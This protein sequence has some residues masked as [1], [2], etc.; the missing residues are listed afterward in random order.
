MTSFDMAALNAITRMALQL[1]Q[2]EERIEKSEK[3]ADYRAH[4][5]LARVDKLAKDMASSQLSQHH[6]TIDEIK[7]LL[8]PPVRLPRKPRPEKPTS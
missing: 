6:A 4:T 5:L 1:N 8:A 7:R 3:L 2:L